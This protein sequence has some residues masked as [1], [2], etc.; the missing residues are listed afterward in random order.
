MRQT[1]LCAWSA[2][3]TVRD[4]WQRRWTIMYAIRAYAQVASIMQ[5]TRLRAV[6]QREEVEQEELNEATN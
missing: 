2:M 4:E 1:S 3:T 5:R 6:H